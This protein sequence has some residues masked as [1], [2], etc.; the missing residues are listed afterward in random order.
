VRV[1]LNVPAA[2]AGSASGTSGPAGFGAFRQAS[3]LVMFSPTTANGNGG[4]SL[5]VPYFL[6]SRARSEVEAKVRV[7]RFRPRQA[8][9]RR[10]RFATSHPP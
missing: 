6:V 1:R 5:A 10:R 3:G 4:A 8:R 2:T 7:R 9:V